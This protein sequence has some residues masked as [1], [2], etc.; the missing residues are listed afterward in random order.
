MNYIIIL[1]DGA[2]DYPIPELNGQTP[3]M[4]AQTPYLD[5]LCRR[6][7]C[8]RL[9]TVP[10]GMPPGSE[11]ANLAILGYPVRE[12][13]QGRGVLEAASLGLEIQPEDLVMRCNL[14]CVQ[15]GL[16]KNHSAGHITSPE[17]AQLIDYLNQELGN[18]ETH[19]YP[20]VSYRHILILKNG[21]PAIECTPPHDVPG[22]PM[23]DY[24]IRAR[25]E[26]GQATAATLNG[27][28]LRSQQILP[29]HPVNRDR[30]ARGKDPAN[31]VW[32]WSQGNKPNMK[33][34]RRMFNLSGAVISAVDL[35]QGIGAIAGMDVIKV[36]GATGLYDT[37]YAGKAQAAIEAVTRHDLVY[38]HIEASDEA[39]HEGNVKL[40]IKTLED[41]DRLVIR[42]ILAAADS[43][44][45]PIAIAVL[46]DH[47]TPCT[48]K[49][50][51]S[52]PVP[53]VIYHPERPADPV[54]EFNETSVHQGAYGLMEA[55]RFIPE[56]IA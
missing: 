42:P 29:G 17:A 30:I 40:K 2:A 51:T 50:H 47:P 54:I 1:I 46:P 6:G 8:G 4:A 32:F 19:F 25:L 43:S 22:K 11:V 26:E 12:I 31:S 18:T 55:N 13:Y 5:Q 41:I 38:L 44:R 16:I 49:T 34:C 36:E 52:D 37:N 21:H 9:I 35:I 48:L 3:L 28:I 23:K 14:I 39:G 27:L 20:G 15:D 53:F 10:Q 45:Q 24:L 56:L 33:T 7:R